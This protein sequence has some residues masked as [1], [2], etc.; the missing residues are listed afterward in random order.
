MHWL[1]GMVFLL[2][3]GACAPTTA[4]HATTA[5]GASSSILPAG[6][7]ALFDLEHLVAVELT[8]APA[9][10]DKLRE[11]Q[12]DLGKVFGANCLDG[13]I[14]RPYDYVPATISIDGGEPVAA[15][16]RKKG[17]VGSVSN[18]RPSLKVRL[19]DPY[20]GVTRLTLNNNQQDASQTHQC[21][22]YRAFARA[23]VPAP[24]CNLAKVSVN[25]TALGVYSNVEPIKKPFLK[26]AFGRD[27]GRLYEGSL[28][29]FRQKWINTMQRKSGNTD[30]GRAQ[31]QALVSALTEPDES[32]MST[33]DTVL[34]LDAFITFWAM[35]RL[36][37]HW[38]G[39]TNN[40]NNYYVYHR[41]GDHKF[42]F[43]PW[44]ADSLLGDPDMLSRYQA[45]ASVYATS[46]LPRR[47][48]AIP[49]I[50]ERY[51]S[52]LH[53]LLS[54]WDGETM[55]S[56]IATL[57]ALAKPHL[58]VSAAAFDKGLAKV[59]NFVRGRR[60]TIE[61]A[62]SG[63]AQPWNGALRSSP[64][65]VA[66]GKVSATFDTK[67]LS[68][69]PVNPLIVGKVDLEIEL[70]GTV[71][72]FS[73]SGVTATA[74]EE[75]HHKPTVGLFSMQDDGMLVMLFVTVDAEHFRPGT[76]L[77]FNADASAV[78]GLL[79]NL[80]MRS[81]AMKIGGFLGNGTL[82]LSNASV[83]EGEVVAGV[84]NAEILLPAYWLET[85]P[86]LKK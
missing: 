42:Q 27:D 52:R 31:L 22:G 7:D 5:P 19:A 51:V 61:D 46:L 77:D 35:E 16:V 34:D 69:Q 57:E 44:G 36:V 2:L 43:I 32:L 13:P 47:L 6:T 53:E 1:L 84:L 21:V 30:G 24:R 65:S 59:R 80:D 86:A 45:P 40:Q 63:G 70:G 74:T 4:P 33:L 79:M 8:I 81:G 62:V 9:E 83:D 64:C 49:E 17:Y 73:A 56:E 39:Y 54:V 71:M 68:A 23:G 85:Q 67:W 38:D 20:M 76:K 58:H 72:K 14:K 75:S 15:E 50:R 60:K 18:T 37:G 29:D 28:T 10:W 41:P 3:A 66:G 82:E 48:Y 25:G 11:Q 26:R 12:H 55:L 78:S